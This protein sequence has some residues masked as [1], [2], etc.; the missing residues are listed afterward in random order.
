ML[1]INSSLFIQIANFLLLVFLLNMLLYRPIRQI[2]NQR[3]AQV[4][5]LQAMIDDFEGKASEYENGI[6]ES[7]IMARKEGYQEREVY[8]VQ[9]LDE[10]KG[11]LQKATASAEEKISNAKNDMESSMADVRKVLEDQITDFSKELAQKI[12]GRAF[13]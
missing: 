5:S 6:E 1:E 4:N 11:I 9:G 7:K 13:Q 8:K 12:L 3:T 2:L 10:E